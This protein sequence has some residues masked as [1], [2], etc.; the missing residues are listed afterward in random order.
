VGKKTAERLIVELQDKIGKL[1]VTIEKKSS[2]SAILD[3]AVEALIVL[4][5]NRATAERAVKNTL[6][7]INTAKSEVKLED[8]IR[9]SL[10]DA[11]R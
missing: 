6:G 10:R 3:E 2:N 1:D 8:L 9:M 4:G 5:W 11:I 7:A